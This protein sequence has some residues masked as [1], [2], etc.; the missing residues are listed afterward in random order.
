MLVLINPNAGGGQALRKWAKVEPILRS[1][2]PSLNEYV[3]D[4]EAATES[5][6]AR[7]LEDGETE[8]VAGGG[9]GTVNGILN[10]LLVL[11]DKSRIQNISLGAI[12]LGSSN[13]FHKPFCQTRLIE[14]IPTSVDFAAAASR[15]VGCITYDDGHSYRTKYF[16]V[17]ASVGVTAEAN[18]FFNSPD[19]TLRSLKRFHVSSAILY[20]AAKTILSYRN[21]H[22]WVLSPETG[23]KAVDLTNLGVVKNPHF[24]GS[25]HYPTPAD[26]SSGKFSVHLCHS[27]R[28]LGLFSLL[29]KLT[30][31]RF[32]ENETSCSWSTSAL[33][34][35]ADRPFATEY[36]GEIVTT[37][38]AHF[39]IL[40]KHLKVCPC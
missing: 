26:C 14:G 29:G 36:D 6:I 9:D 5:T 30:R 40:P 16:L 33:N 10:A 21:I 2:K 22:A 15:D 39:S 37:T 18:K 38:R 7:A 4:G 31:G 32:D 34:V 27:L 11:A 12:G 17:N 24:S 1:S 25:L 13:D 19:K 3:L 23:L 35:F 8:F 28:R 20:A